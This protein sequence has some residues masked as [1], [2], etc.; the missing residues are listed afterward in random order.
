MEAIEQATKGDDSLLFGCVGAGKSWTDPLFLYGQQIQE[1]IYKFNSVDIQFQGIPA[2][3]V[4]V[5]NLTD[6][7]RYEALK[8]EKHFYEMLAATFSHEMKTPLNSFLQLLK[9]LNPYVEGEVG[10]RFLSISIATAS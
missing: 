1:C 6:Y 8:T 3:M 2:R 7:F 10:K 5:K 4:V 9:N